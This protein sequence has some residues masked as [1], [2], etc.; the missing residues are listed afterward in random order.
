[1]DTK[2]IRWC[3]RFSNYQKALGK[4][5]DVVELAANKAL[6]E[7]EKEGMIQ[8]FEYTYELA[9]KT[10][11]DL[12]RDKGFLELS[13]PNP[14]I[15]QAFKDGIIKDGEGWRKM[16]I[17][18]QLASH[19]YN[20]ETAEDIAECIIDFY[21]DLLKTLEITLIQERKTIQ[22]DLF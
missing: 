18:R 13:R 11:Q 15:S 14:V 19:T 9:W 12:L 5:G 17:S 8:R 4:L 10:L 7:L 3:Q 6:S 2:D 22:T 20:S 16:K 1:M 21:F